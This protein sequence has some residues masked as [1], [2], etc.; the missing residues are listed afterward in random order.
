MIVRDDSPRY[1]WVYFI[2]HTSDATE[3]F[4]KFVVD[5]RL[6]GI[7]SES[8]AWYDQMAALNSTEKNSEIFAKKKNMKQELTAADSHC[9]AERGLPIIESAK[10]VAR[11]QASELFLGFDIPERPSLW[12]ETTS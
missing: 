1:A 9:V 7:P 3:A 11:T 10:L 5:L 12:A 8:V 4:A 2:S 6:E